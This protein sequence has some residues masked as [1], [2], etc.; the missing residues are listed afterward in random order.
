MRI[1]LP[2]LLSRSRLYLLIVCITKNLSFEKST[3][4]E[5]LKNIFKYLNITEIPQKIK[6]FES[7]TTKFWNSID[8]YHATLKSLK[9]NVKEHPVFTNQRT[10]I[11]VK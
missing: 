1:R 11:S 2:N 7:I 9:I 6:Y 4:V 10:Q 3:V 5:V 8:P